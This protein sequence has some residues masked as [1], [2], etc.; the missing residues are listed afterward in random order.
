M[1]EE[2]EYRPKPIVEICDNTSLSH[3]CMVISHESISIEKDVRFGPNVLI[4]DCD[5]DFKS[6][7][8]L[9]KLKY[10]TS[11]VKINDN[12]WIGANTIILRGIKIGDNSVVGAG[13]VVKGEFPDNSFIVQ[14]K[15]LKLFNTNK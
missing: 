5:H 14:K 13:S 6:E 3:G 8:G 7:N 2:T 12:V 11:P 10:K 9:K 15:R 1:K 4:Y